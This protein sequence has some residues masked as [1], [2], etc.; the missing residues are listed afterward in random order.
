MRRNSS[1]LLCRCNRVYA[2]GLLIVLTL[3]SGCSTLTE[4]GN[5]RLLQIDIADN[6]P[7]P[8]IRDRVNVYIERR[9][10]VSE[11]AWLGI[12]SP[13]HHLI[14]LSIEL[15]DSQGVISYLEYPKTI[16]HGE[17]TLMPV[18]F[19]RPLRVYT[20][21]DMFDKNA[22]PSCEVFV[23]NITAVMK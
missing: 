16:I 12:I 8:A 13:N 19:S 21:S 1:I 3:V 4:C 9:T 17:L 22:G 5:I 6:Q 11:A 2:W 23:S 15:S 20:E 14:E 7:V 18:K 10:D